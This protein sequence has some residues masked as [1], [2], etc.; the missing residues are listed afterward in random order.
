MIEVHKEP[1]YY[2]RLPAEKCIKCQLESRYWMTPHICLCPVCATNSTEE[3]INLINK[4]K[5]IF[6]GD[7][8][9]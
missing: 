9:V 8:S 3:E 2:Q 5:N 7:T 1:S 4:R 6:T